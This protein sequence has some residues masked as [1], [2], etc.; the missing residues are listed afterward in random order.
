MPYTVC[1]TTGEITPFF[2]ADMEY[3]MDNFERLETMRLEIQSW[4]NFGCTLEEAV[5]Y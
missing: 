1:E 3:I 5:G 4:N 2:E